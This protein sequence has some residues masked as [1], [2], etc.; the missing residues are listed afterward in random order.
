MSSKLELV[1]LPGIPMV[2]AGDDIAALIIAAADARELR[3]G[4]V[5]VVAQKIVSKAE[6]RS[7]DLAGVTPSPEAETLADRSRQGPAVGRGDPAGSTRVVRSRPNLIIVQHRLAF[8][9]ANAGVDHSNVAP[10]DD[11]DRVLLLPRD[12]D[13]SAE[14]LRAK[15][16]RHV[17]RAD[18]RHHQRQ[19]RPGLASRHLWHCDR[20]RRVAQPDRHARPTRPVRPVPWR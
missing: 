7:V 19:L 4:D 14:A 20:R 16:E 18:R 1:A 15:L 12:P 17:P 9:M 6:G 2:R 13:A 5:L 3:A 11:V 8:V 10:G